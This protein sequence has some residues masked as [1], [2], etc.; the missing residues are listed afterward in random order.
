MQK[1]LKQITIRVDMQLFKKIEYIAKYDYRTKNKELIQIIRKYISDFEKEHGE[2][3]IVD[4][5][6]D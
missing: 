4:K 3:K 5:K 6:F 2:I 1:N